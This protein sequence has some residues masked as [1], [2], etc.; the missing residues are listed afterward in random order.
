MKK[1]LILTA[2]T[3]TIACTAIAVDP[4]ST[5]F[6]AGRIADAA[7]EIISSSARKTTDPASFSEAYMA[8]DLRGAIAAVIPGESAA[9]DSAAGSATGWIELLLGAIPV[10]AVIT[11]ATGLSP[12]VNPLRR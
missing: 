2:L 9:G 10:T 3:L 5:L 12:R 1:L 7:N 6:R 11:I 8:G 4:A